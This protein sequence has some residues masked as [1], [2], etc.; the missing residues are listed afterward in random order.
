MYNDNKGGAIM[1]VVVTGASGYVGTAVLERLSESGHQIK[2]IARHRGAQAPSQ[3]RW[4]LGDIRDMDLVE[5]FEGADAIIHLIG[6]IREM[7]RERVTF[8]LMHVGT[9][10]RVLTA[11]EAA[12]VSRLVHMSAL[13]TRANA[14]SSYHRTKWEAEK[15]V[16]ASGLDVTMIRPSLMFGGHPPFFELLQSLTRLP[17]VP[18]PGD[19]KT[20]FQPV[21][22][23]D[24]ADLMVRVLE[25][26]ASFGLTMEVGGPDR[27]TLNA[28]FDF[29]A[30]RGGRSKPAKLHVPLGLVGA[31]ARLSHVLPIP[32]TPDQLAMLTEPN[33]T[34][35]TRWHR[36]VADP[37]ALVSWSAE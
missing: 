24:V 7:P 23:R 9:T 2:A 18:V 4:V 30:Q 25:D 22:R 27:F 20:L 13:G 19:G 29:M 14:V 21:S 36:W 5:P 8:E 33:I 17:S 10:Q 26:S 28:L 35:D 11:M 6:I 32:I 1:K 16:A 31:A 15:L 3:V 34:D 12:G 37:Q